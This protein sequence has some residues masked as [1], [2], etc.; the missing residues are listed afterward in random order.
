[1]LE[2]PPMFKRACLLFAWAA[3]LPLAAQL[4]SAL[5][6][7]RLAFA[8]QLAKRGLYAEALK[9]YEAVRDVKAL[10]RDEVRFRLGEAYRHV[11]RTAEALK[12]Y[13]GLIAD[14]PQ[15]RYVDYARLN[16]AL[17]LTGETRVKELVALDHAGASDAIRATALYWLGETLEARAVI[18]ASGAGARRTGLP[19]EAAY[20]GRGISACL[21]CDGAFY[22]GRKVAVVGE[23]PAAR[24]AEAYLA[25]CGA[26]VVA[27]CPPAA[28]A[29]FDGDGKC[30]T[31]L[32]RRGGKPPIPCDGAFLVTARVPQTAF[33]GDALARDAAG[34]IV[35][36][37]VRTSVPGVFAAGD[38]AR[39]RH[40][41]AVIAAG[42]GAFAALEALAFL[43]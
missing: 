1:M 24:G 30:L 37:G 2:C 21:T 9:E 29:S 25:R 36:T 41:Q 38:C 31:G 35:V 23:G 4:S 13:A 15:S 20:W 27:T 12:E 28:V 19:G 10:P 17:L 14:H 6:A 40:K 43:K 18:V 32:S 3:A 5:P 34:Y 39:P 33:L 42:D 8:N 16:R 22:A 7:D 26:E 11:G